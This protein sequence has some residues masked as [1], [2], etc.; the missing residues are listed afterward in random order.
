M[1]FEIRTEYDAAH[2]EELQWVLDQALERNIG[3]MAKTRHY[4]LGGVMIAAGALFATQGGFQIA[5][6]VLLCGVGLHVIDRGRR[7]FMY[8][9]SKIRKK[10]PLAFTGNDYTIDEMGI[11]IIN[12]IGT[13]EYAYEDCSRLVETEKNLYLIMKDNQ[14]VILDKSNIEGGSVEEL[15]AYLIEHCSEELE[16]MEF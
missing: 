11:Q 13:A 4:L 1:A 15:R 3:A 8:M 5:F 16:K 12:A 6:G 14:G 10:M 9:A 2:L 7:Y